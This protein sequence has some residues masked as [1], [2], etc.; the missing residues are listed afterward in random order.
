MQGEG[1]E[2]SRCPHRQS[3]QMSQANGVLLCNHLGVVGGPL[4]SWL[5]P[6]LLEKSQPL[7]QHTLS[8]GHTPARGGRADGPCGSGCRHW[9]D[10]RVHRVGTFSSSAFLA[11]ACSVS[12]SEEP[13]PIVKD[14]LPLASRKVAKKP[15]DLAALKA[16]SENLEILQGRQIDEDHRDTAQEVHRETAQALPLSAAGHQRGEGRGPAEVLHRRGLDG[17]C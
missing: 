6:L 14:H 12:S 13:G 16:P 5:P 7:S 9:Q 3:A 2:D 17:R 8:P 10:F 11:L 1:E 15:G 4:C